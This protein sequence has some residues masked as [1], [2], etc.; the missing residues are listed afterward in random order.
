ML[1]I[2]K[3]DGASREEWGGGGVPTLPSVPADMRGAGGNHQERR[4]C[5]PSKSECSEW[6]AVT[7]QAEIDPPLRRGRVRGYASTV[8]TP[9]DL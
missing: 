5:R 6:F 9:F 3:E 4:A 1:I 2:S 7:S 8:I